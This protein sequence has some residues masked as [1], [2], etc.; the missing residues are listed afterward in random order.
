MVGLDPPNATVRCKVSDRKSC[1][2]PAHP[3]THAAM[4][5]VA[6]RQFKARHV[7]IHGLAGYGPS[8]LVSRK[9]GVASEGLSI[10]NE[11]DRFG[12]CSIIRENQAR[13]QKNGLEFHA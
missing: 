9:G 11:G 5:Q 3:A 12:K 2:N 10:A 1:S 13:R 8:Q 6:D 7:E 4:V